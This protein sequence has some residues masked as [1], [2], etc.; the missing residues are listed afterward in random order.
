MKQS[1]YPKYERKI[2]KVLNFHL[3]IIDDFLL[4]TVA[5]ERQVKVLLEV[6]EK[7]IELSRSTIVCSQREPDKWQVM[8][9]N[10]AVSADAINKRVTKHYKM[11]IYHLLIESSLATLKHG[12][13][14]SF[15]YVNNNLPFTM[16]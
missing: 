16:V 11:Q 15:N 10:D 9:M 6:L 4:N 12:R 14:T 2:R 7:R 3:L 13:N 5:D 8:I 1:D